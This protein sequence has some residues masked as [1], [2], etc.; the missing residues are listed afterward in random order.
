MIKF[1]PLLNFRSKTVLRAF[2]LNALVIGLIAGIGIELRRIIEIES[3]T[4]MLNEFQK[5]ALTI[6]G[7]T[8]V[9]FFVFLIIRIIFGYGDGMVA[10]KMYKFFL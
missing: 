1:T 9:A 8:I 5:S 7:T 3:Y 10:V 2:I 6:L 4:K